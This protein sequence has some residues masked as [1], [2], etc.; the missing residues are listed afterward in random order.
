MKL[1]KTVTLLQNELIIMVAS[2][3]KCILWVF[4]DKVFRLIFSFYGHHFLP[5]LKQII[6]FIIFSMVLSFISLYLSHGIEKCFEE[7]VSL[8]NFWTKSHLCLY[9]KLICIFV[10]YSS[11]MHWL[12]YITIFNIKVIVQSIFF[13]LILSCNWCLL[14]S[15]FGC[16]R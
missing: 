7:G 6:Q 15:M 2:I 11:F 4:S 1:F 13:K 8:F 9:N 10:V 3:S 5:L 16:Q 12:L 14:W